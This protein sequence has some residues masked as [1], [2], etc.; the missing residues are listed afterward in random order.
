MPLPLL[1]AL[2]VGGSLLGG[3]QGYRRSGGNLGEAA[4]GA[5]MG[6]LGAS[7]IGGLGRMA[8]TKLV[9]LAGL[10]TTGMSAQALKGLTAAAAAGSPGAQLLRVGQVAPSAL[11]ALAG[12]GALLTGN[13]GVPQTMGGATR[14]INQG[15]SGLAR[16]LA[17]T[18]GYGMPQGETGYLQNITQGLGPYGN[19][20]PIGSDP[21]AV[22]DPR[23]RDA[24]RRLMQRKEGETLR[25]NLNLLLPTVEKFSDRAKQ[26]DLQRG[27][28]AE[29]V[30]AN[31]QANV[32]QLIRAQNAV[33][34]LATTGM[35]GAT[36]AMQTQ[37]TY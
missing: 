32:E 4:L 37:Y 16:G 15:T 35:E 12:G 27:L 26:R 7:G 22:I 6:A 29:G 34:Q 9:G 11:G 28:A 17:G 36:N 21:F 25:D 5:G 31:I 24:A 13:I 30:K 10:G 33:N 23:G 20:A 18:Y 19:I 1:P 14:G 8:G 2:A 3:V